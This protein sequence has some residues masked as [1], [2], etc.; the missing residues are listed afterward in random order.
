L[1]PRRQPRAPPPRSCPA[2]S[3]P[4]NATVAQSGKAVTATNT[5]CN[6]SIPAGGTTSFGF[7]GTYTSDDSSPSA[8][9]LNG[10]ACN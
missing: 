4:Q 6:S 2:T 10:T 3:T 9:T 8:F 5:S 7:Q 1:S